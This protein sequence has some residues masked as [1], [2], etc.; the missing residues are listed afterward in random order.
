MKKTI[1]LS[2]FG[3]LSLPLLFTAGVPAHGATFI[4]NAP[5]KARV[6]IT[7]IHT[8]A[9]EAFN[10]DLMDKSMEAK[11]YQ[12]EAVHYSV[13]H[14]NG[15]NDDGLETTLS[16]DKRV[17]A[18]KVN[19]DEIDRTSYRIQAGVTFVSTPQEECSDTGC[20]SGQTRVQQSKHFTVNV[21]SLDNGASSDT[22]TELDDKASSDTKINLDPVIEPTVE[23]V[24]ESTQKPVVKPVTEPV[25]TVV[26]EPLAV[27]KVET[28]KTVV[29]KVEAEKAT[30]PVEAPV[31]DSKPLEQSDPTDTAKQPVSV[32]ERRTEPVSKGSEPKVV[33]FEVEAP[34]VM[35]STSE[36]AVVEP[37]SRIAEWEPAVS[38]KDSS[39]MPVA[40]GE[41][42]A[43]DSREKPVKR[44]AKAGKE[45]HDTHK[46][47]SIGS[48]PNKEQ[49][50]NR[51]VGS[52]PNSQHKELSESQL[53]NDE[54]IASNERMT[55]V[56]N[57]VLVGVI[58]IGAGITVIALS[59]IAKGV[60][61]IRR[62]IRNRKN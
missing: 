18:I 44:E 12:V 3:A 39:V 2:V 31:S 56:L 41:G 49:G 38:S 47:Q 5:N 28:E 20:V 1:A 21:R 7:D 17:I 58:V 26:A 59:H 62:F 43:I 57:K 4:E 19:P 23:P 14:I 10:I 60:S 13:K 45:W 55:A 9:G 8:V 50:Q 34:V 6:V 54:V 40:S 33:E 32:P 48:V 61:S 15:S 51:A 16:E 37:K 52:V 11:G 25:K 35:E 27:S 24:K 36:K 29:D 30:K 53:T 22:K 46:G 42:K